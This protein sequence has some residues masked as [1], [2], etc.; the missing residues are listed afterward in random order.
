[1]KLSLEKLT[2]KEFN[3]LKNNGIL[4]EFYP[5]APEFYYQITRRKVCSKKSK[6][7]FRKKRQ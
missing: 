5:D 4:Y 3:L 1:M 2:E 7:I 6:N